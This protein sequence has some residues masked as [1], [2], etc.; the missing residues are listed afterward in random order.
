MPKERDDY[1]E[2]HIGLWYEKWGLIPC[3]KDSFKIVSIILEGSRHT[4]LQVL[5]A[6]FIDFRAWKFCFVVSWAVDQI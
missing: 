2:F 5:F 3:L 4:E 6:N 1:T